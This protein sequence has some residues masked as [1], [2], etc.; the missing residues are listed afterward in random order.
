MHRIV[1]NEKLLHTKCSQNDEYLIFYIM[2]AHFMTALLKMLI[3]FFLL[4]IVYGKVTNEKKGNCNPI[5]L[6]VN[7]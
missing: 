2:L 3:L 5:K 6:K 4:Y 1:W 7:P